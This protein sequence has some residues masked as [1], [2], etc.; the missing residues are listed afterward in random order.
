MWCDGG[1]LIP[2]SEVDVGA[3]EAGESTPAA[4]LPEILAEHIGFMLSKATQRGVELVHEAL[5]PLGIKSRHFGV[6]M[7][8]ERVSPLSQQLVGERLRIDRT[9]MVAIVDDLERLGLAARGWDPI[10]RRAYRVQLTSSGEAVLRRA[11][12]AVAVAESRFLAPLSAAERRQLHVVL[13]RLCGLD[14]DASSVHG[15]PRTSPPDSPGHA[16]GPPT[17]THSDL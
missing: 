11:D 9:T 16:A 14:V 4:P 8:L 6:L 13:R 12:Q 15:D 7:V 1:G 2:P 3:A 5:A 10:D 17:G